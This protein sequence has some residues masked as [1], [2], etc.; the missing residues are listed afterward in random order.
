MN[1]ASLLGLIQNA[2]LLLAAAY[3]F[4]LAASRLRTGQSLLQQIIIGFAI[5][6]I[7]L[8]IMM[9]PWTFVPGVVFDTRSVLISITGLF[10]G[11]A[12]AI[13]A[14]TMTAIYRFLDGGAGTWTGVSVIISS[15]L[16]GIAWQHLRR[17]PPADFSWRELYVFGV[18]VHL[19]MLA[20]MLT[21][22]W[23]TA[24][25]VLSNITL[26]VMLICPLGTALLGTLMVKRLCREQAE[27]KLRNANELLSMYISYSPIYTFIKE[28]TSTKC[29][30]LQAS[31]NYQEMIGIPGSKMVGKTM[32]ELFPPDFAEKIT[33]DDW[34]V[35]SNGKVLKVDEELNGRSYTTIKFPIIQDNKNLLAGY[36]IDITERKQ[37][38]MALAAEKERLAV[39]LRSIGDGVITTNTNGYIL[40]MNKMAENLTGYEQS[41]AINKPLADVFKII[42]KDTRQPSDD[43]VKRALSI[44]EICEHAKHCLLISRDGI[45]RIISTR[46]APIIDKKSVTIGVVIAFH[47]QTEEQKLI[48]HLQH[49]EKLNSLGILA[50]GIAHDF[51]NMLAGIYGYIDLAKLSTTE[52]S[53]EEYLEKVMTAFNRAKNLTQQ[54]LTFSKG[55][56]P[57]KK[58]A[59]LA[60]VIMESASFALSGSKIACDYNLS[61]NLWMADF[62][63]HQIEQVIGNLI[64]NAQ[65]AMPN[66]GRIAISAENIVLKEG[67]KMLMKSGRY[68]RISVSDTGTGIQPD[69]LKHIF[70][71]FFTTKQKGHGLGL[72][73]S[74]A[75]IQKHEGCIEV[76]TIPGKGSTFHVF[77]PASNQESVQVASELSA[78]HQ[79]TGKILILDDEPSIR[80]ILATILQKMGYST[81]EARDG[82]E[83]LKLF[84]DAA[85]NGTP[86]DGAFFD[87]T[88]PG[89][90]GGK[91]TLD[92]LR[93]NYPDV[94]VYAS[95]G[96]SED[97]VIAKPVE[98]G[99]T[100]SIRKPYRKD[101]VAEMLNRNAFRKK[102]CTKV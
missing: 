60:P 30:V 7:G 51:N 43:P 9:T 25:K 99:F 62:D 92:L 91:E 31:E 81:L 17:K 76:E 55:G 48:E 19:V 1:S 95:S 82:E 44:S 67:E 20:L 29:F 79:G 100:D 86:I 83:A 27:E 102:R 6:I 22:P 73:T 49:T 38:E 77:L 12:S 11:T 45:E 16:I 59:E 53:V 50:G 61:K 97:P 94:A 35:V 13:I 3:L 37:A 15:G 90:L 98:Y 65:Q 75:I 21:F 80:D 14:I 89:G 63:S 34:A 39:T 4:D 84:E 87:L 66:S 71:P 23:Q 18:V 93:K 72:S 5:G 42:N 24:T 26:P 101:E 57:L 40:T 54:L 69:V 74:R 88:I 28:V 68:I 52:K 41:E 47:D 33:K 96:Y 58:T 2:A 70:D 78:S 32:Y 36:T 46:S 85:N 64:I 10:F 8:S 56:V